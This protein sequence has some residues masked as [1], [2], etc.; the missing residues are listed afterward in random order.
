MYSRVSLVEAITN[1]QMT[2]SDEQICQ[3]S[4]QRLLYNVASWL[5]NL[6]GSQTGA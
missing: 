2:G 4:W 3:Q 6:K 5:L 1:Q